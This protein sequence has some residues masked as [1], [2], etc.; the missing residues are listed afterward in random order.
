MTWWFIILGLGALM[1][2]CVAIALILRIRRHLNAPKG[3]P[4]DDLESIDPTDQGSV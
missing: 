4:R 2:V 1:V 3:A